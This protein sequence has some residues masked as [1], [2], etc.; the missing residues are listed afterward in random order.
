MSRPAAT[1]WIERKAED[2]ADVLY[3]A[4]VWRLPNVAAISMRCARCGW[5]RQHRFVVDGS[6]L[7]ALDTAAGFIL[8]RHLANIGC[9]E[10]MVTRAAST[11]GTGACSRWCTSA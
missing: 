8:L 1:R 4:G 7:E 2:G 9:T 6:R 3:L 11:R 5:R 10:S